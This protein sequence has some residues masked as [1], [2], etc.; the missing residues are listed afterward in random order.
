MFLKG[1]F[2]FDYLK[3][4]PGCIL[5]LTLG[6]MGRD[7]KYIFKETKQY[8]PAIDSMDY[9]QTQFLDVLETNGTRSRWLLLPDNKV[10]LGLIMGK[11]K[12]GNDVK[13][14]G[15]PLKFKLMFNK[16]FFKRV[17][18]V[19][20]SSGKILSYNDDAGIGLD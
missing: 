17:C 12:D 19:F 7:G 5:H 3:V 4:R 1:N 8:Y 11:A 6:K 14:M 20:D 15:L 9:K 16:D 2:L 18:I 13:F 10:I